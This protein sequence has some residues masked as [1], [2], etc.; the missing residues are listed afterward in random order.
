[1]LSALARFPAGLAVVALVLAFPPTSNADAS[2]SKKWK[3]ARNAPLL[4]V[5][6]SRLRTARQGAAAVSLGD[7]IYVFGGS[8]W[9]ATASTI[10]R[11]DPA[12]RHVERLKLKPLTRA[13]HAAL[14]YSGRFG[15]QETAVDYR[16]ETQA[17]FPGQPSTPGLDLVPIVSLKL[18][19]NARAQAKVEVF[20][21]DTLTIQPLFSM[22]FARAGM[23]AAVIGHA[24][25][26]A[27]GT[28]FSLAS[29]GQSQRNDVYDFTTGEWSSALA[30]LNPREC[31]AVSVDR[32]MVVA[33]GRQNSRG[34]RAVEIFDPGERAWKFL[35]ALPR[36]VAGH[37]MARLDRWLFLFGGYDTPKR[38]IAYDLTNR[39]SV[40]FNAS[41]SPATH[42]AA[43][44]HGDRI[45]IIGGKPDSEEN[46][47]DLVQVFALNPDYKPE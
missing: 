20:D 7:Y 28:D 25:Y 23:A 44:V 41:L 37:S 19:S 13:F 5:D 31:P 12:A 46:E 26:F 34:L 30:M 43:V 3:A 39:T 14:P 22:P 32:L 36:P 24:A 16:E 33:G 47:M 40:E 17:R 4:K 42:S 8:N 18:T 38:I 1:M 11:I 10:E 27:G 6:E 29:P 2:A 9:D 35:P 15:G 21:P 45:Y